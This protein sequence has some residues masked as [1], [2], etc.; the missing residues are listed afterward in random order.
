MSDDDAPVSALTYGTLSQTSDEYDGQLL[1]ELEALYKGGYAVTRQAKSFLPVLVGESDA[2][3][4]ERCKASSYQ[5]YFGQIVDQFVSDLFG[6]PLSIKPAA[7][8]KDKNTPGVFPDEDFYSAFEKDADMR[9]KSFVDVVEDAMRTALKK[10]VALVQIDAPKDS[11]GAPPPVSRADEDS[12][13]STRVYA[14][15]LPVD[16]LIDWEC[17]D[18]GRF[19]WCILR[20]VECKRESP[21]ASRDLIHETFTV[22]TVLDWSKSTWVRYGIRY[23]KDKPPKDDQI[24]PTEDAGVTS[25][26][27]IPIIRL[28]MPDGLWVGNKIGPQAKEHFQRRSALVS[29]EYRSLV[30]IPYVKKG[31]EIGAPGEAMPAVAQTNP[32]RANHPVASFNSRGWLEMGSDDEVGFAEPAGGCYELVD[33]QLDG[34]KDAMFSVNHQM[35]AS[36]R[37]T[38]SALGRSGLSKQ[39]DQDS[40]G[41]VLRALGHKA[42]MFAVEIY[43]TISDGRG[44][45][46]HWAP[47]GLDGYDSESREEILEEAISLDQ[48]QIP[49]PTF[50]KIHKRMVAEKLLKNVDPETMATIVKE[51]EDGVDD[52]EDMRSIVTDAQKD[53]IQN[54]QAP[55]A[56]TVKS[57]GVKT[58]SA[59]PPTAPAV[60]GKKAS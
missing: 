31:S 15:E 7:D 30:A 11:P 58:P 36:I 50:R 19:I 16:Q 9:G 20:K 51:I 55:K 21:A 29:A 1:A 17:D 12:R 59:K 23:P 49:S 14:F 38:S 6:Q 41:R 40:T 10:R 27:R 3:Y 35:A 5:P 45:D 28:E 32:K 54:P 34:L 37:P 22:W 2:R 39:K 43:D 8:A 26:A 18:R 46:V 52:E 60:G 4:A 53:A 24:V 44:E 47:H 25:F 48:V 57:P 56:P 13:G 42:R 33:K